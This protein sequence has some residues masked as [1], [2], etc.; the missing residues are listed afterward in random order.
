M[1]KETK[2]NNCKCLLSLI[3]VQD[4][5]RQFKWNQ[6]DYGLTEERI[7]KTDES[8]RPRKWEIVRTKVMTV[9]RWY[10]QD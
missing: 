10:A 1:K 5:W 4:S 9:M 6:S 7:C 2:T 3:Q 8:E